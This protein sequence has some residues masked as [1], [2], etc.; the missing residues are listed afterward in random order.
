MNAPLV[1]FALEE[2]TVVKGRLK[3]LEDYLRR[4]EL[5]GWESSAVE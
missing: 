5:I 1:G 2:V 3:R 4:G